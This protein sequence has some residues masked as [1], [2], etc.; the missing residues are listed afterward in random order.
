MTKV[1]PENVLRWNCLRIK[2]IFY[3]EVVNSKHGDLTLWFKR[4]VTYRYSDAMRH[5]DAIKI[6]HDPSLR[7]WQAYASFK[8]FWKIDTV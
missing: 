3:L 7:I 1:S 6:R 5:N 2:E 4:P 8:E